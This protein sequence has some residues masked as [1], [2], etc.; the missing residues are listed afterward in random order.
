L[1]EQEDIGP[2]MVP[3]RGVGS[4]RN[5]YNEGPLVG[6]RDVPAPFVYQW[7][8]GDGHSFKAIRWQL[9]AVNRKWAG[10]STVPVQSLLGFGGKATVL[11]PIPLQHLGDYDPNSH[12]NE[13]YAHNGERIPAGP[14]HS[15]APSNPYVWERV[16]EILQGTIEKGE[17]VEKDCDTFNGV[18]AWAKPWV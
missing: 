14:E 17:F 12:G 18:P 11:K 2:N 8:K 6:H 10:D 4:Q 5:S 13:Y 16:I 15:D 3:P 1:T 9:F 7:L